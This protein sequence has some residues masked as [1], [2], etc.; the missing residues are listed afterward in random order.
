MSGDGDRPTYLDREKKSFS[1]LDRMRRE[2]RD[3]REA[4]PRDAAAQARARQAT[5]QHLRRAEGL[6]SGARGGED[7]PLAQAVLE[8]RGSPGLAEA[9][10]AYHDAMGVPK[11]LRLLSCF[12]DSGE[13][14]LVLAALEAL[15]RAHSAGELEPS[16]GL[17]TQLR[18][19]AQDSDDD[20]AGTAEELLEQL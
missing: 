19:L 9:C 18:G 7:H 6:F 5:K 2:R 11:P 3:G 16:A 10:R 14:E 17:R 13:R 12:L 1:E 8:A 4:G 20:V 15:C